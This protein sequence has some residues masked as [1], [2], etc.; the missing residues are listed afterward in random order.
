MQS[1]KEEK[2]RI[3]AELENLT[4]EIAAWKWILGDQ[5]AI[6]EREPRIQ[7]ITNRLTEPGPGLLQEKLDELRD[8]AMRHIDQMRHLLTKPENVHEARVVFAERVGTFTLFPV[9]D[10]RE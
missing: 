7:A 2:K 4:D 10:S 3:E 6:A 9:S 8:L 5:A 1:L